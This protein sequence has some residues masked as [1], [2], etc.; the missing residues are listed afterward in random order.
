LPE[1]FRLRSVVVLHPRYEIRYY[2]EL[3]E[4]EVPTAER[5]RLSD[6]YGAGLERHI[7]TVLEVYEPGAPSPR[8]D[9]EIIDKDTLWDTWAGPW[10]FE[11]RRDGTKADAIPLKDRALKGATH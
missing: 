5:R 2:P 11:W 3:T 1:V 7:I 10:L 6:F 8:V 4:G 9:V